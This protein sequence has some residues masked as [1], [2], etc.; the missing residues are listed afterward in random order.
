MGKVGVHTYLTKEQF[1]KFIREC[2]KRNES[3]ASLGAKILEE[4]LKTPVKELGIEEKL[5]PKRYTECVNIYIYDDMKAELKN[6][7]VQSKCNIAG[8]IR[9]AIMQYLADQISV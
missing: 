3:M 9:Y 2:G 8:L 7:A 5:R 6:R 1:D 4:Y